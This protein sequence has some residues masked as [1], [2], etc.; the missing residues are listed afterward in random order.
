MAKPIIDAVYPERAFGGFTRFDG[1]VHFC[2]RVRALLRPGDVVLDVGC[3]RGAH[4]DDRC[5]FRRT[6]Q[7]FRGDGR[8][9]IGIDVE[10]TANPFVDEVRLIESVHRWPM[11]DDSVDIVYSNYVLEHVEQPR[12]FIAEAWRVLKPG[13]QLCVRTPNAWSYISLVARL[14]PNRLHARVVAFA[15]KNR[16][17][18]DVFPTYYRCNTKRKLRRLL[19]DQ[20][21]AACVY[22]IEG[23]PTYMRFSKRA[24][25]IAAAAHRLIPPPFQSTL[26]AFAQKP[27]QIKTQAHRAAA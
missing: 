21:F 27:A 12:A 26:L 11:E 5:E 7:D 4:A 23:E 19:V 15:Q 17:A 20:Q 8:R 2:T 13:G 16:R 24:Y 18:E 22:S 25:R 3:G 10:A 9:V 14:V 1:T 6:L